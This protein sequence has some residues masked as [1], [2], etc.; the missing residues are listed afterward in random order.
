M[1]SSLLVG[2]AQRALV[3]SK[4][5]IIKTAPVQLLKLAYFIIPVEGNALGQSFP[6]SALLTF[7]VRYLLL[8]GTVLCTEGFLAA[9]LASIQ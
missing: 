3:Y 5:A 9:S 7:W 2:G 6:T 4:S 1:T 8:L